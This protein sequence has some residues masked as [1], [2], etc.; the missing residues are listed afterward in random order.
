[1]KISIVGRKRE[2]VVFDGFVFAEGP[3]GVEEGPG[4]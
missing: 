4:A 1:M 3:L 2:V